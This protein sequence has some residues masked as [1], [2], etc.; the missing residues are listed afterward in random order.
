[1]A[2][3]DTI[4][5]L[6]GSST[7]YDWFIKENSEIIAKLNQATVSGVTFTVNGG[8]G[9]SYN[10]TSGLVQLYVGGT[11][12][13]NVNFLG[14]VN[15]S[16]DT[17][18]PNNSFKITGITSGSS[19]FTFGM[20][21]YLLSSGGYTT[22]KA[23]DPNSAEVVGLLSSLTPT[24]SVVTTNGYITGNF[25]TIAGG[26]LSTGC[27]Y[28]V[29]PSTGGNI[30]T[31]EPTTL[32]EV[33]KPVLIGLGA[34]AGL[35]IQYRGNYLNSSL[36]GGGE[37]GSHRLYVSLPTSPT[38]PRTV[39]FTGG[40]FLSYAPHSFSTS[41]AFN[42]HL[43]STGRTAINGW[44]VSGTQ[45]WACESQTY[46]GIA[47]EEDFII[48]MVESITTSGGNLIYQIL[49]QG[50]STVLPYSISSAAA[51]QG[52]WGING[53]TF[54][55]SSASTATGITQLNILTIGQGEGCKQTYQLGYVF[56]S[57]PT[58]WYVNPRPLAGYPATVSFTS[59]AEPESL[60]NLKNYT[61]NGNYAVWQRN[62]GKTQYTS[63]GSVYF[64]DNWIRRFEGMPSGS[65]QYI[66]RQSFN[67]TDTYVEGNPEYYVNFKCIANP[68]GSDPSGA[69]C[70][71]GHVI[72][73]IETFNGSSTTVSFYAKCSQSNYS[74]DVYFARYGNSG[75]VSRDTIGTIN[76]Q[77]SW[78]KHT[79]NYDV[80]G[81]SA[82]SYANDY[83]EIGLDLM[84][85]VNAG[86]S[87]GVAVGTGLYVSLASLVVYDGTYTTPKHSF[88]SNEE[89]QKLAQK[90]YYS[91]YTNSQTIGS[92]TMINSQ[93]PS[94]N[95][96]AFNI[97]PG[98]PYSVFK[99]PTTMRT[100]PSVTL[101][102]P[103]SG[104]SNEAYN[105]SARVDIRN[106]T[107][108]KG[109][110]NISRQTLK[111][112]TTVTT[113]QDESSVKINIISGFVDYDSINTHIIAD[114][115]YPI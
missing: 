113:A 14:T 102:S 47:N 51:K 28:F 4:S 44:F 77:T 115:S 91:T 61:F 94:L 78:T 15:F 41:T 38:D 39:G 13:N 97:L 46:S 106:T 48:G 19:G 112:T 96:Y 88:L 17:I 62:T 99:F 110:N 26:T 103:Y 33:S 108:T 100:T 73:E 36:S 56:D 87:G 24:Y 65:S 42:T 45:K 35:V 23:N 111:G 80:P 3:N 74:A 66:E 53:S 68:T 90:Y 18:F 83:V 64:A 104:L 22:S 84:P 63:T 37:S 114:A 82:G 101:Y 6:T 2:F 79:L 85:L 49:T 12:S 30:T 69:T 98:I 93:D 40:M 31:T 71:V 43:T 72:D 86:Y 109:Y 81:L 10:S 32:G 1:M 16:S 60:T 20:P 7:F 27:I 107:G 95:T 11:V 76:L 57:S 9:V 25:Q 70:T 34:T 55:T 67:V 5:Q 8:V 50:T 105:Y 29:S 58:Y 21:V 75:M 54:S 92:A 89:Q 59:T 52:P